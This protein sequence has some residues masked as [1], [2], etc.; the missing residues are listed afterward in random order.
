MLDTALLYT[1]ALCNLQCTYCMIDKNEALKLVDKEIEKSFENTDYYL[2]RIN[3]YFPNKEELK[4]LEYWGGEPILF[5]E[6]VLPV[7]KKIIENYK[8]LNYIHFSTN[9]AYPSWNEKIEKLLNLLEN[10]PDREFHLDFQLSCD[11][12]Q[13]INDLGRGF[14]TTTQCL[15]NFKKLLK[16][17]DNFSLSPNIYVDFGIK[18]TLCLESLDLLYNS[19]DKIIDYYKFFENNF[20]E[21]VKAL[22]NPNITLFPPLPNFAVPVK[23]TVEDGKKMAQLAKLCKEIEQE[24]N[25]FK[26][27]SVITPMPP[28]DHLNCLTCS[29]PSLLCGTAVKYI[30]FLPNDCL[31][32][33][34]ATFTY[35]LDDYKKC[36]EEQ[37]ITFKDFLGNRQ[38]RYLLNDNTF[39][40]YQ[41]QIKAFGTNSKTKIMFIAKTIE[42]LAKA[43]QVQ[44]KYKNP[45]YALF[46]AIYIQNHSSFCVK[47][48][49][50]ESGSICL[51]DVGICKLL[52]NGFEDEAW[53]EN[54][55]WFRDE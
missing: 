53:R 32:A 34:H 36:F 30:G 22:K 11:G 55:V 26:Y 4:K 15:K 10:Y 29:R 3:K 43:G 35:L 21:P 49:Y 18:P 38:H 7:T 20:I 41:N 37:N 44:E 23:A 31:T 25:H 40:H 1:G 50:N 33:C 6:R 47:D 46:G 19:K 12:P 52:L 17:L 2:N 39:F 9:F 27:Y 24:N 16:R 14:G 45:T 48:N 28:V 8:N 13:Y 5:I 51:Q 42:M 54:Y